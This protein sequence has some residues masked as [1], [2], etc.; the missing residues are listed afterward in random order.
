[1]SITINGRQ[2]GGANPVYIIAEGGSNHNGNL[3]AAFEL[4][5]IAHEAGADAIKFQSFI[6]DK[7]AARNYPAYEIFKQNELP[8]E[9]HKELFDYAKCK[10]L[11]FLSTPFDLDTADFLKDLVVPALKVASGDITYVQLVQH[12]RRY[13]LP[14]ILSTG[15][16]TL[17]EIEQALEALSTDK[18]ILLHCV[19]S[20]PASYEEMNLKAIATLQNAFPG[21]PVGL[22][23][24][25][26]DHVCALGA[27]A[28]GA[29]VIEKHITYNRTASGPDHRFAM[30]K[31]DFKEYVSQI[32]NLELALGSGFKKPSTVERATI[33]RGRRSI[34]AAKHISR[35]SVLTAEDL[36]V[37]RPGGGI[38]PRYLPF[39]IGK[40]A[41]VD[42]EEDELLTW[43]HLDVS[44]QEEV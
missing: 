13:D 29:V 42:L 40:K 44:D 20:Y 3:K 19:A 22:S 21:I 4:I 10:G 32:R 34:H 11:D 37:V 8:R 26:L 16:S 9:W 27:V 12:L 2:I 6:A 38:E 33:A 31:N 18:V 36:K 15:K 25:T 14:V 24:H 39:L 35:G 17:G 7:I 28:L 30:E 23:D 1:M 43:S 41:G 5:D